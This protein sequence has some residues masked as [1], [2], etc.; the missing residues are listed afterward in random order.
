[1]A[2]AALALRLAALADTEAF[3]RGR[4]ASETGCLHYSPSAARCVAPRR[5]GPATRFRITGVPAECF[6]ASST[7][8]ESERSGVEGAGLCSSH[9]QE[10]I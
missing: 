3:V 6:L 5:G 9:D 10:P 7:N 1:M 4:P 8:R 2:E